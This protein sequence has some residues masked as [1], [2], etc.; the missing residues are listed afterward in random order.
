MLDFFGTPWEKVTGAEIEAF[1]AGA[2]DEGLLW[3]AKGHSEP[4]RDAVR[5]AICGFAN[6]EGGFFIVGAQR[7]TEGTWQLPGVTF[8]SPE[9]ATWLASVITGGL[10]PL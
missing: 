9:P 4:H 7:T 2:G 10:S 5:K 3:E 6:A 1:L 8:R